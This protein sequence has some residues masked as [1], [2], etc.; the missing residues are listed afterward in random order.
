MTLGSLLLAL[1]IPSGISVWLSGHPDGCARFLAGDRTL[2]PTQRVE[3]GSEVLEIPCDQWLP[4]Q[5]IG[6]QAWC[7]L[8]LLAV[9]VFALHAFGDVR[10]SMERRRLAG[11]D[12]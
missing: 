11:G 7:L 2:P 3:V 6:V 5:P 10:D 9:L 12:R 4:R 8:E 1:L